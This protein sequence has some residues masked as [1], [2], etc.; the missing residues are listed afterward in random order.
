MLSFFLDTEI[1]S[2]ASSNTRRM[3]PTRQP[4]IH[5]ER[6][7]QVSVV[8]DKTALV[9]HMLTNVENPIKLAF[10]EEYGNIVTY[11]WLVRCFATPHMDG[12]VIH[13]NYVVDYIRDHLFVC[14]FVCLFCLQHN[15]KTNDPK[16]FRLGMGNDLGTL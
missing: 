3:L 1:L 9:L 2:Q 11:L 15:S 5:V 6:V 7:L 10:D 12:I 4:V 14:L 13:A 16:V 8:V